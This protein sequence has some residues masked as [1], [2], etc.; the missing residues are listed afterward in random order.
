MIIYDVSAVHR[1][2]ILRGPGEFLR[3]TGPAFNVG[4]SSACQIWAGPPP[5]QHVSSVSCLGLMKITILLVFKSQPTIF[6]YVGAG[7][8]LLNQYLSKDKCV[9][10]KDTTQ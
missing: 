8:P 7:L 2:Q 6:S 1:I 4:P 10:L 3:I 5:I 9:L